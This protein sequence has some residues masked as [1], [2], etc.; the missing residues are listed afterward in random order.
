MAVDIHPR[1]T[2]R[3]RDWFLRARA[4]RRFFQVV[5]SVSV[6]KD[7]LAAVG[8]VAANSISAHVVLEDSLQ[9]TRAHHA[10]AH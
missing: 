1:F 10:A 3:S 6:T 2:R 4:G 5:S 7:I 8:G 9:T